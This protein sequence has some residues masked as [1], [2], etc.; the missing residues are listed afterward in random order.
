MFCDN[1]L[2][3]IILYYITLYDI[4]LHYIVLYY[5]LPLRE[6][7]DGDSGA[8]DLFDARFPW[9]KRRIEGSNGSGSVVENCSVMRSRGRGAT[10]VQPNI[11]S[12][13]RVVSATCEARRVGKAE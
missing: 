5:S 7:T 8:R 9:G 1:T 2:Y 11:A 3:Y 6:L 4:I 13:G 10:C 12:H